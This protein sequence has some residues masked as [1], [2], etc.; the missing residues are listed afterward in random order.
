MDSCVTIAFLFNRLLLMSVS[1]I[2]IQLPRCLL[3]FSLSVNK[4][5]ILLDPIIHTSHLFFFTM[6]FSMPLKHDFIMCLSLHHFHQWWHASQLPC[7]HLSFSA[8]HGIRI[9]L[10]FLIVLLFAVLTIHLTKV[11][12]FIA[13]NHACLALFQSSRSLWILFLIQELG[14][15]LKPVLFA[16]LHC[17]IACNVQIQREDYPSDEHSEN[18]G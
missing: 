12:Y 7:S 2:K 15:E 4:F 1:L 9:R 3:C 11:V 17:K 13:I 5:A 14:E 8:L 18:T 16:I 6:L 10:Y